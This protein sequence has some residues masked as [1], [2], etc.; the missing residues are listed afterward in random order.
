MNLQNDAC[1]F[2]CGKENPVGLKMN[3]HLE[4][5]EMICR[6]TPGKDHQGWQNMVHGGIIAT[7]VDEVMVQAVIQTVGFAVTSRM[8][9]RFLRPAVVGEE[10]TIRAG[11]K[12]REG[13][14]VFTSC[15]VLNPAGKKVAF[16]SG[17]YVLC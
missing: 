7:L 1:C 17:T 8:D 13:S 6:Y 10:L 15:Q 14:K 2:A 4:N 16:S 12:S 3:F 9:L 5:G 11:I